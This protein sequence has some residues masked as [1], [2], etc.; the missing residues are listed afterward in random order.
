LPVGVGVGDMVCQLTQRVRVKEEINSTGLVSA[1]KKCLDA[2]ESTFRLRM[3]KKK[4]RQDE[5]ESII[6]IDGRKIPNCASSLSANSR[7]HQPEGSVS[8]VST[9]NLCR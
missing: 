8:F 9:T 6:Y 4:T 3:Q 7:R 2:C 5:N 1:A